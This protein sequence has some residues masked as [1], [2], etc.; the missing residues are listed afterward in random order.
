VRTAFFSIHNAGLS[1][2]LCPNRGGLD[3]TAGPNLT[4]CPCKHITID[5]VNVPLVIDKPVAGFAQL[6][7]AP[8]HV[9]ESGGVQI[10][11]N[12][13]NKAIAL[14]SISSTSFHDLFFDCEYGKKVLAGQQ[15]P[16]FFTQK[17][18]VKFGI[19]LPQST[20]RGDW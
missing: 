18:S 8:L 15:V 12:G 5:C 10:E 11:L 6:F 14:F 20:G 16:E 3:V 4:V 17:P 13:D 1:S 7:S 2:D 9:P 19:E